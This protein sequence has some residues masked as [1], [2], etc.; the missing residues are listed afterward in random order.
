MCLDPELLVFQA[1]QISPAT[2][3][4]AKKID[5]F[6][7]GEPSRSVSGLQEDEPYNTMDFLREERA[8]RAMAGTSMSGGDISR[9]NTNDFTNDF[10]NEHSVGASEPEA[11]DVSY[12]AGGDEDS[13][14]EVNHQDQRG[15][16]FMCHS[17][18]RGSLIS[19]WCVL[20]FAV[21]L[22]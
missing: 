16:V 11:A 22:Q 7:V 6:S 3:N 5:R 17:I 21:F 14:S 10:T 8:R 1:P 13:I 4:L 9:D 19:D 20:C 2:T 15:F 18:I 12:D